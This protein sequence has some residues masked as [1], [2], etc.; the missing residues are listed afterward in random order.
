MGFFSS[1]GKFIG[2]CFLISGL[3]LLFL[4]LFS[5]NLIN[6]IDDIIPTIES[7][8]QELIEEKSGELLSS[9][10]EKE[11]GITPDIDKEQ[12]KLAC[13]QDQ[14]E[15][16]ENICDN[17][18]TLSEDEIFT[19][20]ASEYL[21]NNLIGDNLKE[22]LNEI[23]QPILETQEKLQIIKKL[24]IIP[25]IFVLL[26]FLI[27]AASYKFAMLP[28][29]YLISLLTSIT[30]GIASIIHIIIYSLGLDTIQN[31]IQTILMDDSIPT[32]FINFL[33][34]II[35]TWVKGAISPVLWISLTLTILGIIS[36]I[37]IYI[38]KKKV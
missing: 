11:F 2:S 5:N 10:L 25:L 29:L 7:E 3:I 26:G 27:I 21:E 9:M 30:S 31:I 15:I 13:E 6:G 8:I 16:N 35:L 18:D 22:S 37:L 1:L 36:T 23:A 17:I 28:T 20:F 4:L 33:A 34:K 14:T 32:L 38:K 12:I 24:I 19:E